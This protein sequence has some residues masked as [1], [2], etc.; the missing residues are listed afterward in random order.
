MTSRV[1]AAVKRARNALAKLGEMG[2]VIV[3]DVTPAGFRSFRAVKIKSPSRMNEWGRGVGLSRAMVG[4]LMERLERISGYLSAE[5]VPIVK[6]RPQDIEGDIVHLRALG[7]CN[8]QRYL[9]SEESYD[10]LP[11]HFVKVTRAPDG[12]T[13]FA[14]ASR[15]FLRYRGQIP[16]SS[17]STGLAAHFLASEA[18][19]RAILEALERHFHHVIKFNHP[20]LEPLLMDESNI[21]SQ[22]AEL[23][24]DLSRNGYRTAAWST[25]IAAP[26]HCVCVHVY[27]A[28]NDAKIYPFS[29]LFHF[30]LHWDLSTAIER[31]I[32]ESLVGRI[33]SDSASSSRHGL[34]AY[35]SS[36]ISH[37]PSS[38]VKPLAGSA[39]SGNRLKALSSIASRLGG[40]IFLCDL[41]LKEIGIPVYRALI[42]GV[43][44]NF[45]LMG[46][47]PNHPR[48]R[49]TPHLDLYDTVNE[50]VVRGDFS[51]Q[52][53]IEYRSVP[54]CE[55][56]VSKVP[57]LRRYAS[58]E[59]R[60]DCDC[61]C[62]P[63]H[64]KPSFTEELI[65]K[66]KTT[67]SVSQPLSISEI[68]R[69]LQSSIGFRGVQYTVGAGFVIK[70][71][72]PSGGARHPLEV[73]V[74]IRRAK[75]IPAGLYH[76]EGRYARLCKLPEH[77]GGSTPTSRDTHGRPYDAS[78]ILW[79]VYCPARSRWKYGQK[80]D[81]LALIEAG[82]LGQNICLTAT[83]LAVNAVPLGS[84]D[85]SPLNIY[86]DAQERAIY[87]IELGR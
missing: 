84:L 22:L 9:A 53:I 77:N 29:A 64:E 52:E 83:E 24:L 7:L 36:F 42:T 57:A 60:Y 8:F 27:R 6:S 19:E 30:A 68:G 31:A 47:A 74:E 51:D 15:V 67:R 55:L 50:R 59:L 3:E 43:Q 32:T 21:D 28:I 78:C 62:L 61:I 66:R 2:A 20:R 12:K 82:H 85:A 73:F 34:S 45:D 41:T 33:A 87:A 86:L 69:I 54:K 18:R 11:N 81:A 25:N 35:E 48:S 1:D 56:G 76:Y 10:S 49:L 16:D 75:D 4:G 63:K 65:K 44:P 40:E 23:L 79:I 13:F 71:N 37:L 46:L 26:L 17:C 14:P 72:Y 39:F 70:R 5:Q 58:I 38:P 80:S